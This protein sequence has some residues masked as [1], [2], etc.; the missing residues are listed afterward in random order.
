MTATK[1]VP[2]VTIVAGTYTTMGILG[3][4]VSYIAPAWSLSILTV[5][6]AVMYTASAALILGTL[7]MVMLSI[8]P[9]DAEESEG[10]SG[11]YELA[12]LAHIAE[13]SSPVTIFLSSVMLFFMAVT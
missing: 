11:S 2:D 7:G 13:L 8:N 5:F 3:W 1:I 6:E 10:S 9:E 4:L 12:R